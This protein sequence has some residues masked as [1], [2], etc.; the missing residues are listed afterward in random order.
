M[1]IQPLNFSR[2]STH[3]QSL[4]LTTLVIN[5]L[6]D[7]E[8]GTFE[9]RWARNRT[10]GWVWSDDEEACTAQLKLCVKPGQ[11]LTTRNQFGL[12]ESPG[13]WAEFSAALAKHGYIATLMGHG[14]RPFGDEQEHILIFNIW[15]P[16]M[17]EQWTRRRHN[18]AR[19]QIRPGSQVYVEGRLA[20]V[21]AISTDGYWVEYAAHDRRGFKSHVASGLVAPL[22]RSGWRDVNA[23]G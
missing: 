15:A 7:I 23:I 6:K 22:E 21:L 5:T 2:F 10:T 11:V 8:G 20:T 12:V 16:I 1:L 13:V 19:G 14:Q 18:V 3:S 17:A 9:P 4:P